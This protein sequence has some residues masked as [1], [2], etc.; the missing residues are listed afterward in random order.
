MLERLERELEEALALVRACRGCAN[1]P[2]S[3]HCPDC[4]VNRHLGENPLLDLF[5]E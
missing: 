5:W 3:S 4:P 1:R 2:D